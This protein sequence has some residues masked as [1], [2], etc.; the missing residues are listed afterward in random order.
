MPRHRR[1]ID[2]LLI[3]YLAAGKTVRE[4]A[5]LVGC[6]EATV[7]RR[8][9]DPAFRRAVQQARREMV[10]AIRG[11]IRKAATLAVST[12]EA[13]LTSDEPSIRLRAAAVLMSSF[14]ALHPEAKTE[15]EEPPPGERQLKIIYEIVDDTADL[16]AQAATSSPP[17]DKPYRVDPPGS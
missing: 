3:A 8:L 16:S 10:E 17:D 6:G 11:D 5:R 14:Q 12:L 2:E 13:L 4:T 9:A 1:N 15:P 7:H